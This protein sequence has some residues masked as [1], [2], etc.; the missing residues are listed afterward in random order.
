MQSTLIIDGMRT[1]HCV[2]AVFTALGGVPAVCYAHVE[3]GLAAVDH[4]RPIPHADFTHA[5]LTAGYVLRSVTTDA[6]TL[7]MLPP[8]PPD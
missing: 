2:R 4:E 8:A 5:M 1:V 6:R 3:M 7:P